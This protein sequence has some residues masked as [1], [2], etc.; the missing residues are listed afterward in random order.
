MWQLVR[1]Q[2]DPVVS[3]PVH[4]TN[5]LHTARLLR[6]YQPAGNMA[7]EPDTAGE[8]QRFEVKKWNAVALWAW[9]M[10]DFAPEKSDLHQILLSIIALFVEITL[11]NSV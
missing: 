2:F 11:W 8:K 7:E 4:W 9:G 10:R 5:K 3:G 1:G 6:H